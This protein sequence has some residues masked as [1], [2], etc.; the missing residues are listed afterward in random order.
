M[1][2]AV[3]EEDTRMWHEGRERDPPQGCGTRPLRPSVIV[4]TDQKRKATTNPENNGREREQKIGTGHN[5]TDS[6][7][8]G[9]DSR[10]CPISISPTIAVCCVLEP[11]RDKPKE[12]VPIDHSGR[13]CC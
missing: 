9:L 5:Q 1:Q 10:R 8:D 12:N 6:T 13:T 3:L 2:V 11:Q 4:G 7:G